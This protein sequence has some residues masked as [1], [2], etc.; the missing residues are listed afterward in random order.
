MPFCDWKMREDDRIK[1][2]VESERRL[3]YVAVTR[4]KQELYL[5]YSNEVMPRFL[6]EMGLGKI[7]KEYTGIYRP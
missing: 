3:F 2:V 7:K 5:T 1:D 6:Q 4:A